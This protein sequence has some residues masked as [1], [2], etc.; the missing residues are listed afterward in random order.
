M[1]GAGATRDVV[2]ELLEKHYDPGYA[3]STSRNFKR[4]GDAQVI[5]P[6][7]R[8]AEAMRMLARSVL[9]DDAGFRPSP[10]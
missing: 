2:R 3:S 8:S 4:F 5:A 1:V 6:G 10:E 7:D 9:E